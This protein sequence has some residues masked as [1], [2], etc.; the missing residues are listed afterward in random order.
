[1][2]ERYSMIS[3]RPVDHLMKFFKAANIE[4]PCSEKHG[5]LVVGYTC[6]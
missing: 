4:L 3:Q 5:L 2:L 6:H 1:M